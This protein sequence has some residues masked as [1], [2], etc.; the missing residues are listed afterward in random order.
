MKI[1]IA[2]DE[3]D[4]AQLL[5]AFFRDKGYEVLTV[6]DGLSAVQACHDEAPDLVLLDIRMPRLNGWGVLEKVRMGASIPIIVV[7]ALDSA[8]DAVKGLGLGADD[9]LR[10]PFDLA[11]LDAR[12]DAVLR[13]VDHQCGSARMQ[14]GPVLIDDRA[15]TVCINGVPINLSPREY[16][17]L[18]LL[19]GTPERVFSHQEIIDAVWPLENRADTSDVKQYVHLLRSKIER[20]LSKPS[21]ILT[22]KGFGY[23]FTSIT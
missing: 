12:V 10:K 4:T 11:E 17:L 18:K 19:A 14:V 16:H 13:R 8:E 7:S 9:Y 1:L 23:K 3:Q 5:F 2:E 22:V 6:A 21:L 15:K 20:D